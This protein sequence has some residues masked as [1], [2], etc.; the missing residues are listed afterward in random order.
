MEPV[1][2][3][4]Y[5]GPRQGE[6]QRLDRRL[7][8]QLRV[9]TGLEEG[10]SL[11]SS[12]EQAALPAVLY[13]DALDA[14]G[15]GL[16]TWNE[17]PEFFT[18]PLREFLRQSPFQHLRQRQRFNMFGRTYALGHEPDLEDW[19]LRHTVRNL[20]DPEM[21]WAIWYPLRRQGRFQLLPPEE[22]T[23]ALREHGRIG[24]SFGEAG[25]ARDVRLACFGL[26]AND[27]DFVIGLLGRELHPLSAC[28]QAMRKTRQTAELIQTMGPFF[29]GQVIWRAHQRP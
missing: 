24:H 17:S 6:R 5:G 14:W 3:A 29:T 10:S 21:K 2:I 15:I 18:G 26:D 12:L 11:I 27:N 28:V 7:F 20:L 23:A 16:I 8:V 22:Q 13:T 4:E 9:F 19:L 25:L 1:D